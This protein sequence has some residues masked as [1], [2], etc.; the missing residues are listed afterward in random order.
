VRSR[1]G[2]SGSS[3]CR[4]GWLALLLG[5]VGLLPAVGRADG[6]GMAEAGWQ[7]LAPGLAHRTLVAPGSGLLPARY[8]LEAFR[9]DIARFRP[10][11]ADARRGTQRQTATVETLAQERRALLAVNGSYFDEHRRP[12]GLL[13]E[14]GKLI[15]P[16]RRADWGVLYVRAG[17][18]ALVHTREFRERGIDPRELEFAIQVGPRLVSGGRTLKLKPQWADRAAI[19]ILPGGELVGVVNRGGAV[20]SNELARVMARSPREGGL[21][22][23]EAVMMDGGPSA[24]LYASV[25]SFELH[26]PGGYGVPIA[27]AFV[28]R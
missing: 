17:K 21:G 1:V 20:E 9:V 28:K 19:G 27:V 25:G 12:L 16:L 13:V 5:V 23:R 7:A 14:E 2:R 11:V 8:S 18:A 10:V 4:G 26:R 3:R 22:C 15:R 24:Q 6:P